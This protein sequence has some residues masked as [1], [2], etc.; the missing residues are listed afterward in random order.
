[1]T[2]KT[3]K[4]GKIGETGEMG[5]FD[6]IC[7]I[8][9]FTAILFISIYGLIWSRV[10]AKDQWTFNNTP[11]DEAYEPSIIE[12]IGNYGNAIIL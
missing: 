10:N 1:E 4:A 6:E 8:E 2:D 12:Y 9:L 3:G 7:E 5:D 11:S